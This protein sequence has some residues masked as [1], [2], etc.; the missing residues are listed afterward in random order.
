[1]EAQ[2]GRNGAAFLMAGGRPTVYNAELLKRA[3]GYLT[4]FKDM[5]DMIPSIAGLACVLGVTRETCHT[6][7]KDP[8]KAE[9][10]DIL[11]ELMQRQERELINGGIGGSFNSTITK[12]VL[13]KHGYSDKVETDLK[14]SDGSMTPNVVERV[15]IQPKADGKE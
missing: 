10:S 4:A 5:G 7:A 14:S 13:S 9:F 3:K 12:L 6:W 15:I 11:K 2:A 8:E 1:M